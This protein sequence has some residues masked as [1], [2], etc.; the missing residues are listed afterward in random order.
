[1]ADTFKNFTSGLRDPIVAASEAIPSDSA[2]LNKVTRALYVGTAGDIRVT[3]LDGDT[4]TFRTM[5]VGW[6]PLRVSRVWQ[7]GTTASDIVSCC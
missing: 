7:T 1:M 3:L 4:V 5:P 6:H 2:D